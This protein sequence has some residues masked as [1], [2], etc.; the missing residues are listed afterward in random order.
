MGSF[1]VR[2][3][4]NFILPYT[5]YFL[6][7]P[8]SLSL[9]FVTVSVL[10][11]RPRCVVNV[12]KVRHPVLTQTKDTALV[13]PTQSGNSSMFIRP[14]NWLCV[15]V[16]LIEFALQESNKSSL[17]SV[18][19]TRPTFALIARVCVSV[20]VDS[21]IIVCGNLEKKPHKVL[22]LSQLLP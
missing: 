3:R 5:H 17:N 15:N 12:E 18:Y 21:V 4:S 19:R 16:C 10:M 20:C 13:A 11:Q 9:S 14:C 1:I 22:T 7:T 2:S 6:I 8:L